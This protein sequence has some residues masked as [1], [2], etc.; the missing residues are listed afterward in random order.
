MDRGYVATLLFNTIVREKVIL[1]SYLYPSA[2]IVTVYR[3]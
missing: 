2:Q 3:T 1:R